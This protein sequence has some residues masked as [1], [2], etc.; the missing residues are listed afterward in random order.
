MAV[1]LKFSLKKKILFIHYYFITTTKYVFFYAQGNRLYFI[2]A[3]QYTT[4]I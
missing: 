1:F 3:R 4:A 2:H